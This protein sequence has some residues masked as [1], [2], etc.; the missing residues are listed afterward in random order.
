MKDH[1]NFIMAIERL[2]LEIQNFNVIFIG[3]NLNNHNKTLVSQLKKYN[4]ESKVRLLGARNDVPKLLNLMD[5]NVLSS[6]FGEG[7]PTV[8]CE[9]MLCGTPCITTDIGDS[10]LIVGDYGWVVAPNNPQ[11]LCNHIL[12]AIEVRQEEVEWNKRIFAGREHIVSKFTIEA[13]AESYKSAWR[14]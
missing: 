8:L 6:S 12:K 10:A 14:Q 5:V 1:L 7:Q 2:S 11:E 13:M 4:I 3:E 9:R